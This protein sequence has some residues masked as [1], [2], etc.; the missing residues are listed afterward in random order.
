MARLS[1]ADWL[2]RLRAKGWTRDQIQQATGASPSTQ[3]RLQ[4]GRQKTSRYDERIWEAGSQ[5]SRRKGP[6]PE[7]QHR[8]KQN[9]SFQSIVD[10][11]NA[12]NLRPDVDSMVERFGRVGTRAI[13]TGQLAAYNRYLDDGI[14]NRSE[15][16]GDSWFYNTGPEMMRIYGGDDELWDSSQFINA[17]FYM[18]RR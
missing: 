5:Y 1:T 7:Y 4:S 9:R 17:L 6:P 15:E 10:R 11:L 3:Y 8:P 12:V 16:S 18:G 14:G 2:G 13:L